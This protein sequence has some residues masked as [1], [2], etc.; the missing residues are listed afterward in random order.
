MVLNKRYK[1]NIKENLSFYISSTVLTIV[2]LLLFFLFNIAGSGINDFADVFY[3]K[4]NIEDAE[5]STYM[6][7][8]DDNISELEEKYNIVL[9]RQ[10]Y[11][12]IEEDDFTARV[13]SAT[14]KINTY[15]ITV[16]NDIKNNNEII[17][18]EGYAVNMNVDIGDKITILDKEYT[19]VGYFQRP[20]YLYMLQENDDAYKNISTFFLAYMS[21]DD[22]ADLGETSQQYFIKYNEDNSSTVR[23]AIN[24]DYIM[25]NY[26][27]SDENMRIRMVREQADIFTIMSYIM[28]VVMPLISVLLICIILGR[29]VKSEQKL[30]GTL[31]ALGYKKGQLMRHYAGFAAIPGILGGILT[32]IACT[33]FAQPYGEMSLEDYEPMRVTF[34]LS[35]L[36]GILGIIVPTVM[37]VIAA[38]LAVRKMLNNDTVTLLNGAAGEKKKKRRFLVGSKMPLNRK[39]ALRTLIAN[40]AR[41]LAL[42]IGI[43]LG[44]FIMLFMFSITDT[45]NSFFDNAIEYIGSYEYEYVLNTLKT[46]EPENGEAIVI[47]EFENENQ[48]LL[49]VY[50]VNDDNPYLNLKNEN[51]DDIEI[52]DGYYITS[53]TSLIVGWNKGD[54]V[55]LYNPLSL[56]ENKIIIDDVIDND[57]QKGIFTS[58]ANAEELLGLESG[59]YNAIMTDKELDIDKSEVSNT[60]KLSSLQE[61][62]DTMTSEMGMIISLGIVLGAIICI[63]AVY[64]AVNMMMTENR[65]N[66]SMLKVLGYNDSKINS[67]VLNVNHILLPIG[68]I[69]SIP[70]TIF[71]MN[72]YMKWF[73][74]Y[75]GILVPTTIKPMSYILMIIITSLCYFGSVYFIRR[76]TK[77]IDMVESLKDNRE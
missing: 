39:Y 73:A 20:D 35:P 32:Y 72:F 29:K 17:I 45:I 51:G 37:Y 60:I 21:D 30:I 27:S 3:E 65:H 53:V 46:D 4:T 12:N 74:S 76:K 31:S 25:K 75:I 7:L 55:T 70:A 24:D 61:Q 10:N 23:K 71:A 14:E 38:L 6:P 67:M 58:R 36:I 16:G 1:R 57:M 8:S 33:I 19:V 9:E 22:F 77:K 62:A 49:P 43:F 66:I 59:A 50:G 13:F 63:A 15:D 47:A 69:I 40:P 42:L 54:E 28:L 56:E 48:E 41:S 44:S 26:M 18:S 11:I 5:F 64:V 34:K 2:T 52:N 68:I